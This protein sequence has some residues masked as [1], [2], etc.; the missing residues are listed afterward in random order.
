MRKEAGRSALLGL[1]REGDRGERE[2]LA[3]RIWL[4]D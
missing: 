2:I 1:D 3:V 4:L